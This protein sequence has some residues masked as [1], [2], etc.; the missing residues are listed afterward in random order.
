M[1][2]KP[3]Q[4]SS[5][6]KCPSRGTA[7]QHQSTHPHHQR[8][9]RE[10]HNQ[11]GTGKEHTAN[12][13]Y[14]WTCVSRTKPRLLSRGSGNQF[15]Y[16]HTR[17]R[18]EEEGKRQRFV[19]LGSSGLSASQSSSTMNTAAFQTSYIWV[20]EQTWTLVPPFSPRILLFSKF[21]ELG[22]PLK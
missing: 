1:K 21:R 12:R 20:P 17:L 15:C 13:E 10:L 7:S 5:D 16:H 19:V 18:A 8:G 3:R 14:K 9:L 4:T 11:A 2:S 22:S 6:Q